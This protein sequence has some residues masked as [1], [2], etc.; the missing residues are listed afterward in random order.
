MTI[1]SV[2]D[3]VMDVIVSDVDYDENATI[4][5]KFVHDITDGYVDVTVN[6]K[7]YR[8][9]VSGNSAEITLPVLPAG[10]YDVSVSYN[11]VVNKTTTFTVSENMSPILIVDNIIMFYHD[12]TRFVV[13][14]TG[15]QGKP[16]A[17]A[18]I[19]FTI[20]GITY[21]RTT[22]S[23]G[24]ASMALNLNAGS[25]AATVKYNNIVKM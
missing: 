23:N 10:K 6:G 7:T 1:V 12:G 17:N 2:K 21:K 25:Y 5:I 24:I 16:I 22:D 20:N 19:Y 15:Y 14:L 4:I 18:T 8:V 9:A 3:T 13:V 11:G